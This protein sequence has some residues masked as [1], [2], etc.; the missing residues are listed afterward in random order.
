MTNNKKQ[1]YDFGEFFTLYRNLWT[2]C[3][4]MEEENNNA[5]NLQFYK[6]HIVTLLCQE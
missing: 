2:V 6:T 1:L 5:N 4:L 3:R